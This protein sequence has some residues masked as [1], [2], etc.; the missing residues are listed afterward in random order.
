MHVQNITQVI[1]QITFS[2]L[3]V[4]YA[5]NLHI[6]K[7]GSRWIKCALQRKH[8]K[9]KREMRKVKTEDAGRYLSIRAL[10]FFLHLCYLLFCGKHRTNT[11]YL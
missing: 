2:A 10:R 1:A 8:R 7:T 3:F 5:T 11:V 6:C 9:E 4:T